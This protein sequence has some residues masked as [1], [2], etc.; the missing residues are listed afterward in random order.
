MSQSIA[1][2][3]RLTDPPKDPTLGGRIQEMRSK[4]L[5]SDLAGRDQARDRPEPMRE[6]MKESTSDLDTLAV[7]TQGLISTLSNIEK[8]RQEHRKED[9][10][11]WSVLRNLGPLQLALVKRLCTTKYEAHPQ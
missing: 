3:I 4:L 1:P 5:N 7:A 10:T 9:Q 8:D 2:S 6:P 11:E